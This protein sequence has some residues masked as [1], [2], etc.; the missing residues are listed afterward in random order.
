MLLPTFHTFVCNREGIFTRAF[1]CKYEIR[2]NESKTTEPQI[3]TH[4]FRI[5]LAQR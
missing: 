5:I 2:L 1:K 4:Y 3:A